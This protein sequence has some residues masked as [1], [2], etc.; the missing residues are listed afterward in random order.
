[1]L[2]ITTGPRVS[3]Y[4]LGVFPIGLMLFFIATGSD[5][6]QIMLH[7]ARGQL[8]LGAAAIWSLIGS[9]LST[10]VSKVEY[11][12]RRGPATPGADGWSRS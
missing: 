10:T 9:V 6:R 1:M 4:V 5:Y 3:S 7:D 12:D 11:Y 2:A 8:M